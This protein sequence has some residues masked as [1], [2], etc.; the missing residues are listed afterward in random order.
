MHT[1]FMKHLLFHESLRREDTEIIDL[2]NT[3]QKSCCT[4]NETLRN[5]KH[6]TRQQNLY[7]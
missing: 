6:H 1:S 5:M 4:G 2:F 7:I 3:F